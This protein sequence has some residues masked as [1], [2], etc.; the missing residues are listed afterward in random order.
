M[1][2]SNQPEAVVQRQLN[3]FNA[4]DLDALLSVYSAD[5]QF[6]EY[7]NKLVAEG[8]AALRSRYEIRFQ[9]PNL[10]ARLLNRTVVGS[11]VFDHEEVT[12]SFPEGPGKIQLMMIYEV[13]NAH[14]I[15]AWSIAGTKALE[16]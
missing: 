12:R 3:A 16:A 14:I 10:H 4:R 6:F 1:E 2:I 15:K 8:S 13:K 11:Y 5:A 7:P 9:E